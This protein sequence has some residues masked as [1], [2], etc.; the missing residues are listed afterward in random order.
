MGVKVCSLDIE[1]TARGCHNGKDEDRSERSME[2]NR[3]LASML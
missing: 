3:K 2:V 1:C